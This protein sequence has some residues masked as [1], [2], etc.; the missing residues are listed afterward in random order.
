VVDDAPPK[1]TF[2]R[3]V[4]YKSADKWIH[5]KI[6]RFDGIKNRP[7]RPDED[8]VEKECAVECN[9]GKAIRAQ[10]QANRLE[11]VEKDRR[12]FLGA[13]I[14]GRFFRVEYDIRVYVG[15]ANLKFDLVFDGKSRSGSGDLRVEWDREYRL[16]AES[17]EDDDDEDE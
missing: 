6:V 5:H 17:V 11:H 12:T 4:S 14:G 13:K 1:K 10:S 15:P 7:E 2:T 16:V 9:L 8:K 3:S